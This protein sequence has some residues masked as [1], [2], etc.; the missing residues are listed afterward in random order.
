MLGSSPRNGWCWLRYFALLF[1]L[2]MPFH[3]QAELEDI[4]NILTGQGGGTNTQDE[5]V[6][7]D[8]VI[9]TDSNAID[10]KKIRNRLRKIYSELD[11]MQQVRIVDVS[12]G[13][14]TLEGQV[15][16]A[17]AQN[18]AV[19]FARQVEGVVEVENNLSIDRTISSRL[20]KTQQKILALSRDF[21]ANLP[22]L[23]LALLM[24]AICWVLGSWISG[25]KNL[26]LK[27]T[28]NPFIANLFGQITRLCF[29]F[30][31]IIVALVLLDATSLISSTV[32]GAAGILGL[33]ISFAIR[34]TVENYIASILLSLRHP[35]ELNDL[36][37]I[38]GYQGR[39]ARLTSRATVLISIDGNQIR[40]PN[41]MVFKAVITN[42]TRN[43][44]RRFDFSI[45]VDTEIDLL[46]V[47]NI[48]LNVLDHQPGILADPK[49]SILI[50]QLGDFN[51]ALT[52]YAWVDQSKHD[53][54]KVRSEAIR[55]IKEAFDIQGIIIPTPIYKVRIDNPTDT[56]RTIVETDAWIPS[57][58]QSAKPQT[59]PEQRN[60][61]ISVDTSLEKQVAEE[62]HSEDSGNN[63]LNTHAPKE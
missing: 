52:L 17:A 46:E 18:R 27:L 31:G 13:V 21:I 7:T 25:W 26:F 39:V 32:L 1:L 38:G 34:D 24:I 22:V 6:V 29:I 3:A 44:Q 14:V 16:S 11:T 30:L 51:V 62:Q 36:V 55:K 9:A 4:T 54:G 41:A 40:I 53:W 2:V 33:A 35:F 5:A 45:S 56:Q 43:P 23:L 49:P 42:Y 28:P 59:L 8:R 50:D 63:L 57:T 60:A 47:Q 37:L 61:D 15:E 12:S 19:Q 48:A 20:E 10:D 58:P